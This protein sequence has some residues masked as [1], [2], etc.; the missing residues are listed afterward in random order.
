MAEFAT[1]N[2]ISETTSIS[3]FFANYG[4][5]PKIDFE[6]D[7]QVDNPKEEEVHTLADCLSK[8]HEHIKSKISFPQD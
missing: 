7:I 5:N 3:A 1:N 4:L 8:I 2:H 6:P